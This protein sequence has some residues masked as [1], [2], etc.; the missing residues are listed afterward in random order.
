MLPIFF[1]SCSISFE[2]IGVFQ[3]YTVFNSGKLCSCARSLAETFVPDSVNVCRSFN[4]FKL[5]N[6][7]PVI[8]VKAKLRRRRFSKLLISSRSLSFTGIFARSRVTIC[9]FI[10]LNSFSWSALNKLLLKKL[11]ARAG[12]PSASLLTTRLTVFSFLTSA[13]SASSKS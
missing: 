6:P 13:G 9:F 5:L 11:T 1:C 3:A 10:L 7:A 8:C 12:E 4:F 2:A